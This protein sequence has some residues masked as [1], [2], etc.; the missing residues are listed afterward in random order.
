VVIKG[1]GQAMA[2]ILDGNGELAVSKLARVTALQV[3]V[4]S[5][6]NG[7]RLRIHYTKELASKILKPDTEPILKATYRLK[8]KQ[9][10]QELRDT[11]SLL[12]PLFRKGGRNGN[13]SD[14]RQHIWKRQKR[15][16][17]PS[18]P[19]NQRRRVF[20]PFRAT[21]NQTYQNKVQNTNVPS[22]KSPQ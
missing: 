10:A 18:F 19:P 1:T 6:L 22:R 12:G 3:N 21:N 8:A 20:K 7:E 17:Y 4:L 11:N 16:P 9:V 14:K 2:L 13:T 15:A 5:R